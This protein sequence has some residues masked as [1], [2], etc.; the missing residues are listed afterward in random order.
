MLYLG[1]DAN[2]HYGRAKN[3]L[4]F[5]FRIV[6]SFGI[7]V[8]QL[9]KGQWKSIFR[10]VGLLALC[11]PVSTIPNIATVV[12]PP[13]MFDTIFMVVLVSLLLAILLTAML[14]RS[15]VSTV[16]KIRAARS[17]GFVVREEVGFRPI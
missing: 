3:Y 16:R 10:L 2:V 12:S 14:V 9:E 8:A 15:T 11:V 5:L 17:Q 13:V 6:V 4:D 7:S 1:D